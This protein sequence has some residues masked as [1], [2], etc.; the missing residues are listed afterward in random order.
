[1][2]DPPD[3][4][5]PPQPP[6]PSTSEAKVDRSRQGKA[7]GLVA[8]I[9]GIGALAFELYF[10][11][12]ASTVMTNDRLSPL[13]PFLPLVILVGIVL[14]VVAAFFGKAARKRATIG[15]ILMAAPFAV[16]VLVFIVGTVS[17]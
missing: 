11:S 6:V 12:A 5:A 14:F 10:I 1:M 17:Q 16:L 8:V 9:Y 7:M 3:N 15:G 4:S 2:T 13:L